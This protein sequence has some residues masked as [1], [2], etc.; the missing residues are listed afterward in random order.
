LRTP[1]F[2]ATVKVM[3]GIGHNGGPTM[4]P[5]ASWR[6]HCWTKARRDLLP[7]MPLEVIGYR[8]KRAQELGLDYR[9]YAGVRATTGRDIVAFLFSSNALRLDRAPVLPGAQ[10][11]KLAALVETGRLAAVYRP[12]DPAT[13]LSGNRGA[14]DHAGHAPT[15][16]D[17]W[18]DTRKALLAL[19]RAAR[20]PPDAVLVVG[21]TS[22]ERDWCGT[23]R[24]AGFLAADRYFAA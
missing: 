12:L 2:R 22:L 13:V 15:V 17:S 7:A 9:T 6:R 4:E 1:P 16:F 19:T 11:A 23:A 10:A 3:S 24:L 21:E 20:L 5:G 18:S 14:I 8:M